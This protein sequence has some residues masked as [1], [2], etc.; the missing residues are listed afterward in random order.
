MTAGQ[1]DLISIVLPSYNEELALERVVSEIRQVM[2]DLG[3]KYE[4]LVVDDGSV[5]KTAEVAKTLPVRLVRHRRNYGVGRA[6]KTGIIHAHGEI[7]VMTDADG[8]YPAKSIPEVLR[9]LQW[10]DMVIG[11]RQVE[12][13]TM[14]LLRSAAKNIIRGL[15][16]LISGARIPDLNSGLRAFRRTDAMRFF[17]ILPDS[18]SWVST[19]TLAYFA[20]GYDVAFTPIEYYTRIGS[21]TFHPIK[22]T[23]NYLYL[24]VR[25]VTF[26]N[27]IRFFLPLAFALSIPSAIKVL[28]DWLIL[29]DVKESDIALVVV[30]VLVATIGMLADLIVSQHRLKYMKPL[31]PEHTA[32]LSEEARP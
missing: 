8:T 32:T 1:P 24:I 27:P 16:S 9:L 15:A 25:T 17:N 14:P 31:T 3:A 21:S 20:N 11:A 18:H 13:G 6:R 7:V 10:N 29:S 19:I 30:S 4:I 22:D 28:Y 5:D 23:W 2:D 12:A 26:F